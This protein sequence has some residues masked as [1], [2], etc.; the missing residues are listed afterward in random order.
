[1]GNFSRFQRALRTDSVFSPGC[2]LVPGFHLFL[3]SLQNRC[4]DGPV[5][6]DSAEDAAQKTRHE[7]EHFHVPGCTGC[8]MKDSG[9]TI[10][11]TA[12]IRSE[13]SLQQPRPN[14]KGRLARHA[15]FFNESSILVTS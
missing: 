2:Q 11:V 13:C 1:M 6:G 5:T 14:G 3:L 7:S 9:E 4:D 8:S 12:S 10:L 15:S